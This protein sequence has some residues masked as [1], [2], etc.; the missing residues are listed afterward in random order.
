MR[1]SLSDLTIRE[2]EIFVLASRTGSLREVARQSGLLPAHV[3]KIMKRLEEK[4]DQPL[5]RRSATGVILTPEGLAF[6]DVASRISEMSQGIGAATVDT[7]VANERLW[8][9][10][11]ISFITTYLLAPAI[12][13]W[14]K[15]VPASRF[16]LIEFTHNDLVAHGL[17]GA[18]ELAVHIGRLEW[19]HVWETFQLGKL[20]WKLYGRRDHPL[21]DEC[22]E[23]DVLRF[24]F[25]VPT[26][27]SVNGYAI[28]DDHCPVA[29]RRR[30]RG[31]E[32]ATA[33]TALELCRH[34][35]QLTFVPSLLVQG[36]RGFRE[37]REIA[38][39]GWPTVEKELF[40]TVKSDV[41]PK[42]L[43]DVLVRSISGRSSANGRR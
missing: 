25:I 18:F 20:Q 42:K 37:M 21:G 41:V 9:I 5:M 28:G 1:I 40:L 2:L 24:P 34:S 35:D 29:V 14:R 17:K 16:R 13:G 30:K 36:G 23:K 3:S 8:T 22:T 27:W 39:D 15:S 32:A 6:L 7:K 43:V 38:V 4:L 10:G 12:D 26:D 11:S 33:E 31:D 19:T